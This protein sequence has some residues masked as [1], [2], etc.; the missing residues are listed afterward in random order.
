[1]LKLIV[2][3]FVLLTPTI[4][5]AHPGHGTLPGGSLAHWIA[6]PGH[7]AGLLLVLG[8]GAFTILRASR[9]SLPE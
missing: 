1:M 3:A 4:A 7:A 2:S 5:A 8:L 6:E 9:P